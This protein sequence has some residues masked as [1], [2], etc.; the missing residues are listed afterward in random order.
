LVQLL[1]AG[2]SGSPTQPATESI[3]AE[4]AAGVTPYPDLPGLPIATD[5]QLTQGDRIIPIY[6][7]PA[8]RFAMVRAT[9]AET[10]ILRR[11][12]GAPIT[13]AVLRP[14][15]PG[16]KQMLENGAVYLRISGLG[17][18]ALELNEDQSKPLFL[19]NHAPES[20]P[21][22][23]SFTHYFDSGKVHELPGGKLKLQ[24]GESVYIAGGAV[25]RGRIEVQGKK[26]A[27]VQGIRISGQ[28]VMDSGEKG[29]PMSL[30]NTRNALVEGI[31]ILNTGGWTLRVFEAQKV[32]VT[33]VNILAAGQ[34]SDGIDVLGSSDVVVSGSFIHSQD[35]CIAIKGSKWG[36]RGNVERVTLEN[37]IIWKA[38]A[39]NGIEIGY[40]TDVDYLRDITV[41]NISI[42]H[43][44]RK[45]LPFRRAALSIHNSGHAAISNVLYEDIT[46]EQASENLIYLWVGRSGFIEHK[47]PGSIKNV[48]FRRVRYINGS[49]ISSAINCTEAP[50]SITGITFDQCTFLGRPIKAPAEFGL[51][52][53]GAPP[54]AFRY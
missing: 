39:G 29:Q 7:V 25:V 47:A 32:K 33:S 13:S 38:Q 9:A 5:Y 16:Q 27:P 49:E 8:G 40:E 2:C 14:S 54:P 35:D 10:F 31:T 30:I 28:G 23:A 11:T 1:S 20:P 42:L 45:E 50:G 36:F 6:E 21:D 51:T 19:F 44:G 12:D 24:E 3:H 43:V 26:G 17:A 34:F 46:I 4:E 37:L 41:R 52:L 18:K 22:R 15:L 48:T 53:L